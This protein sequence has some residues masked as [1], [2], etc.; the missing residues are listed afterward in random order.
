MFKQKKCLIC[1]EEVNSSFTWKNIWV[2]TEDE[3]ICGTCN[4][5]LSFISGAT[6]QLCSRELL[7]EKYRQGNLCF[8]CVRWESDSEWGGYLTRNTSVFNYNDF[9]KELIAKFKYRG[10]YA[11]AEIFTPYVKGKL[12]N[13][14]FDLIVPIPLSEER[15]KERG[16]N[17]A[18]A[19]AETAHLEIEDVL[20]RIHSEKQS[21]KSRKERIGL[22]QVFHVNGEPDHIKNKKI[23]LLDDIYTTGS[24]LRQAAKVLVRAGATEVS[25]LTL[26]R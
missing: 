9:M 11:L 1:T 23:M 17:Q 14:R 16:F 12:L 7:D 20:M 18:K 10:D 22:A 6:C 5:K 19:I 4:G 21:K 13:A 8:D 26:A 24:T 3:I 15:L 25:S 2:E